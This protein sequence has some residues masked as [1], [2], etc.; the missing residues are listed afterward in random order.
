MKGGQAGAGR[1]SG[2]GGAGMGRKIKS[3]IKNDSRC[4]S[5]QNTLRIHAGDE[6]ARTRASDA[7]PQSHAQRTKWM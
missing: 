2:G 5:A 3:G 1:G 7:R 6:S 4:S